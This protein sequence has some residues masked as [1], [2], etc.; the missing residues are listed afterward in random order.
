MQTSSKS[1]NRLC[2]L[3]QL[4]YPIIQAG[5]AGG[6]TT[7]ALVAAVS[8]AGGLGTLGAGYMSPEAIRQAIRDIR[9]LTARPFA[10][11][12]FILQEPERAPGEAQQ[13]AQADSAWHLL[14]P[15][16]ERLNVRED[17]PP[18]VW[19]ESYR[20]Q[21]A[22]LLDER[23]PVFSSTFDAP[24]TD[25]LAECTRLGIRTIG[26][27]TTVREALLLQQAGVDAIVAQGAEAGGHRGTFPGEGEP[28]LIGTMA[29]VPQIADSVQVPVIASGG[30]MD[31]RGIAAALALGA[32]GV[33]FGTAF[34]TCTESGAHPAHKAAVLGSSDESTML[35]RAVSGKYAR[36]IRSRLL[37]ELEPLAGQLPGYPAQNALTQEIRRAAAKAGNPDYMAMWAGQASPLAL[38][39][40]AAELI[41]RLIGEADQVLSRLQ[42][43][44]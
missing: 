18:A 4:E 15:L 13:R 32:E 30:I 31:G 11:N 24:G 44:T 26:T 17:G 3:F 43:F 16:R 29:L 20:D 27:A 1:T 7:P 12:L 5:M 28:P 35:S 23:V 33:Q 42:R 10:V 8:E 38:K 2:R 22:V 40:T 41:A 39:T 6:T 21:L 14:A 25:T 9:E 19:S 34:L 37:E 36:G